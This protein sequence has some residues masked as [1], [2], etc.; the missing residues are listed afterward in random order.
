[1]RVSQRV[2]GLAVSALCTAWLCLLPAQLGV[3]ARRQGGL[4]LGVP[5]CSVARVRHGW[6]VCAHCVACRAD[7]E[8]G[9]ALSGITSSGRDARK[10]RRRGLYAVVS[11]QLGGQEAEA[12]QVRARA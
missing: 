1:M 10:R 6:R 12:T 2:S 4:L 3:L 5:A 7:S 11:I 9:E 8:G